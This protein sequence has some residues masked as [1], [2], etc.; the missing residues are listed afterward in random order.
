MTSRDDKIL[1]WAVI[2]QFGIVVLLLAQIQ[3]YISLPVNLFRCIIPNH[4]TFPINVRINEVWEIYTV[5]LA[6]I[7]VAQ[8]RC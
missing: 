5:E 8:F 6:T 2:N 3:W 7:L 4:T 1:T